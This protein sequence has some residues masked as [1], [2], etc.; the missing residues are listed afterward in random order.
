[1]S[2]YRR[3][4]EDMKPLDAIDFLLNVIHQL[5]DPSRSEAGVLLSG[6]RQRI[7]DLLWMRRGKIVSRDAV[8]EA[9]YGNRD[10]DSLPFPKGLDVQIYNLR[11]ALKGTD[12]IIETAN[13]HGWMLRSVSPPKPEV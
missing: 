9:L 1:M 3:A 8:Y 11:Q 13:G 6:Q 2:D 4:I 5:T 12:W 10:A 7:F